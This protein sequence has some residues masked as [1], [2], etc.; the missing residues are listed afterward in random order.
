M[1]IFWNIIILILY[2]A[3]NMAGLFPAMMI[4]TILIACKYQDSVYWSK[5]SDYLAWG[6]QQLGL[7]EN[8]LLMF[9]ELTVL[10]MIAA[11]GLGLLLCWFPPTRALVRVILCGSKPTIEEQQ[12]ID[13]AVDLICGRSGKEL[14]GKYRF[15]VS[16]SA[17]INACACIFNDIC[18]TKAIVNALDTPELAGVIAHEMGHHANGDTKFN[19]FLFFVSLLL[20]LCQRFIWLLMWIMYVL[21]YIPF[22]GFIILPVMLLLR[23][24]NLF[25]LILSAVPEMFIQTFCSR[26]IEFRADA[27]AAGLGL[28][29]E[30][31]DGL[32]FI[33][34]YYGDIPWYKLLF[35]DHPRGKSRIKHIRKI[36]EQQRNKER[37]ALIRSQNPYRS[38]MADMQ[39]RGTL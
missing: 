23:G 28:G 36:M 17:D 22:L 21:S 30:L 34:D 5:F 20:V 4:I 19:T 8:G 13:G 31:I 26:R 33:M 3:V 38:K 1:S 11:G 24:F 9:A 2:I 32:Q 16:K 37:S 25:Y 15:T 35:V 7:P 10:A 39:G 18:L 29:Q 27:Y 6:L 14:H 12:K